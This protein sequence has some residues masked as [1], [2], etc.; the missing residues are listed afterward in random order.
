MNLFRHAW[1]IAAKDLRSEFR[2]KESFN[3]ATLGKPRAETPAWMPPNCPAS[4]ETL[5]PV[6]FGSPG[7]PASG[8]VSPEREN[9]MLNVGGVSGGVAPMMSVPIRSQS[10][11]R[12]ELRIHAC[13]SP[14]K[15]VPGDT[16]GLGTV[17]ERMRAFQATMGD[18]FKPSP[19]LERLAETGG[20][21]R[22]AQSLAAS[23]ASGKSAR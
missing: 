6:Q 12:F 1:I 20:R 4:A 18:D 16:I 8:T 17:L 5:F 9:V 2:T 21:H 19:L 10:G 7:I 22:V 23:A 11:A 14:E 15:G 3:A 13:R